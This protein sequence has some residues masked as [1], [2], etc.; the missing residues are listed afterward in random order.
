VLWA[1]GRFLASSD[2]V[3]LDPEAQAITGLRTWIATR[4]DVT[5][6]SVDEAVDRIDAARRPNN[7]EA[8]AW[9]DDAAVYLPTGSLAEAAGG[10]LKEQ[11]V[12]ELLDRRGLL[13]RR[14]DA[15]RRAV[16]WVPRVGRVDCYALRRD[17]FGRRDAVAEPADEPVFTV[18]E[19]GR[20]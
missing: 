14:H 1:W 12:A 10:A 18:H 11:H 6:K 15:K 17:A 9:Y 5:V 19:G 13:A 7:R 2:A 4:W 8:L 3:A 16:R 20:A